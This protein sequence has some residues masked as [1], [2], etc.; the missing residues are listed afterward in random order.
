MI[1]IGKRMMMG[2]ANLALRKKKEVP[3]ECLKDNFAS[4]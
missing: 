1:Y 2:G 3:L 4:A